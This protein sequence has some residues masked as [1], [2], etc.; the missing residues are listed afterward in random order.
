METKPILEDLTPEQD[1]LLDEVAEE[2]IRDL[3]VSREPDLA[4]VNRWLDVV[5]GLYDMKRPA[6]VEIALSPMAA[7]KLAA[8]LTGEQRTYTNWCGTG[9]GNWLSFYDTFARIGTLSEE[10]A[11]EF[12]ALRDFGRSAWDTVLLDECAIVIRRPIALRTDDDGNLHSKIGRAS[13]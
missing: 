11:A 1:R 12:I 7:L 4:V 5:Y 13:C 8:E 3:P 2:Y 9:E 10:E 6:R